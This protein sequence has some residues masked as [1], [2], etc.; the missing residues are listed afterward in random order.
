MTIL[1]PILCGGVGGLIAN[2]LG[3]G[4]QDVQWWLV[5]LPWGLLSVSVNTQIN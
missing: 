4:I 2:S 3:F 1:V 5:F